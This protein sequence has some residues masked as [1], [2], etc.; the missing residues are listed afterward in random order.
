[1]E[2][3]YNFRLV[4]PEVPKEVADNIYLFLSR[5]EARKRFTYNL[6]IGLSPDT[7]INAAANVN[8][9]TLFGLPFNLSPSAQQKSGF[10]LVIDGSGEYRQPLSESFRLRAGVALYRAEYFGHSDFDD[11]IGRV[12]AGPQYLF[13]KGDASLLAVG[14][15]RWFGN[16]PYNWGYGARGEANYS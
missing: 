7:N 6:A 5:I 12:Y 4:L 16:H 15:E 11:M 13:A 14:T 1:R 10:G 9:L 8:Q 3:S 2:A